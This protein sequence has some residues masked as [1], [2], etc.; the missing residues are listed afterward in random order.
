M[1][2]ATL[3]FDESALDQSSSL[4]ALYNRLYRG[5]CQA[6]SYEAPNYA[7]NPPLT[8]EG[9]ID[10]EA[11]A[12][13]LAEHSTILMKNSAYMIA[14]SIVS[15]IG[16]GD[17]GG[18]ASPDCL[19]RN[20]DTMS[21]SFG[22]L[23]GFQAGGQG[24]LIFETLVDPSN[25]PKAEITGQLHVTQNILA[26]G[27]LNL[28]NAG[29]HFGNLQSIYYDNGLQLSS[30][31]I[32]LNGRVAI[33]GPL[34]IGNLTLQSSGLTLGEYTY[35]HTGN[36]N[37]S[38][39]DWKMKN[40]YVYGNL[41]VDGTQL[42]KGKLT[43]LNGF[44]LGEGDVKLVYSQLDSAT[45][46][47]NI[48]LASDLALLEG[49]GIALN[50]NYV[51]KTTANGISFS[52][53]NTVMHLGEDTNHIVLKTAIQNYN[54]DYSII[55]KDGDG[56]F[57][58]S[59]S[60]G[61]GNSTSQVIHTYFTKS[62]DC[63]VVFKRNIRLNSE[64]GP[65]INTGSLAN[66]IVFTLPYTYVLNDLQHNE[67]IPF[68]ISYAPTTS[69]LRDRT[70]EWS[71][72][73]HLNTDAEFVVFD[74]PIESRVFAIINDSYKTRLVENALFFNDNV[75]IE[76]KADGTGIRLSG[77]TYCDK[78]ISGSKF[79]S[80]FAGS[81]WAIIQNELG[82]GYTAT[83]DELTIRKKARFYELEVQKHSI[84]NGA[85]WVSDTC[86]G[87]LVEEIA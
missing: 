87:D 83:F 41:T 16:S 18:S 29:I 11:I 28:S 9:E 7:V 68:N 55:T 5:M 45:S 57:P 17:S 65:Q 79:S 80:G 73:L 40:A 71:A 58:N 20:G 70:K 67:H 3:N 6:S 52:A 34:T 54:D 78:N 84:T 51:I 62:D 74:Q 37:N 30:S 64:S 49:Y 72:S 47:H 60:A 38:V 39:T 14:N 76:G 23:Y 25:T 26:D 31:L 77:N 46:K 19:S 33:N 59:F 35:Y 44:E 81:G 4:Y 15:S 22:A 36:C 48:L 86:S 50:D 43:A 61:C 32:Q 21:G 66:D 82:G 75:F 53:P 1:A 85:L 10:V 13:G 63:G 69:W 56:N 12:D 24:K 8:Q 2:Q 42:T 27:Q